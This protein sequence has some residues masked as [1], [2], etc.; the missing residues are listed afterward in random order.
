MSIAMCD[1]CGEIC[2]TDVDPEAAREN[3]FKCF[4][5][6]E[7]E[8]YDDHYHMHSIHEFNGE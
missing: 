6:R 5:C 4:M 7:A 2:D 8:D 3:D 1:F